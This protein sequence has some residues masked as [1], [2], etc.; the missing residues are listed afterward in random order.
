[1]PR[2]IIS[3]ILVSLLLA[4]YAA[5]AIEMMYRDTRGFRHYTCGSSRRGAR[6]AVKALVGDR[7]QIR[8]S[9]YTGILHLPESSDRPSWCTGF[10]GAV[11]SICGLCDMPSDMGS[12]EYKRKQLGLIDEQ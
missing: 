2:R 8:S 7:Y 12:A 9:R 6:V 10:M 11:R 4:P 5:S 1:M 3:I